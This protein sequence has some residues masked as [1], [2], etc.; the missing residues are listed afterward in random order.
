MNFHDQLSELIANNLGSINCGS[1]IL[2]ALCNHIVGVIQSTIGADE[3]KIEIAK[4]C[5]S[6]VT[7][8]IQ[9]N[10]SPYKEKLN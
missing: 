9:K 6:L 1:E 7:D 10:P 5:G 8:A 2:A 4:Q 3:T